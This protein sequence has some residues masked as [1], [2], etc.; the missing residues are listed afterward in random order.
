VAEAPIALALAAGV[1][2]AVNPCG[3][4]LLP[5][6]L[7]LLVRGEAS[8]PD[9]SAV[10]AV[11]RALAAAAAMTAGFAAVFGGFGLLVAPVAAQVQQHLPWLTIVLGL[12]V[13]VV[14]CGC[15]PGG[16]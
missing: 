15:W 16:R 14:G 8:A 11:G 3:F 7:A 9:P 13:A 6:Y 4:A 1:L 12:G 5:A 2:A 10:A